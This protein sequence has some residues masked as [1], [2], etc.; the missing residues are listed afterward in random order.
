MLRI[1]YIHIL[2]IT[3]PSLWLLFTLLIF[4]SYKEFI[5]LMNSVCLGCAFLG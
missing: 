2:Q 5:I 3:Y 4:V 1:L